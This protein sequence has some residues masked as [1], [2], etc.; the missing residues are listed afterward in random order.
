MPPRTHSALK[1]LFKPSELTSQQG[2]GHVPM[3]PPQPLPQGRALY[4][5]T[6]G[7]WSSQKPPQLMTGFP[8]I[9]QAQLYIMGIYN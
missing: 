1:D 6:G 7:C 8:D 4:S 2:P 5:H 9:S 3:D